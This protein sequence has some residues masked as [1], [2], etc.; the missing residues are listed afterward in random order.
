MGIKERKLREFENR[1][2]LILEAAK[3]LFSRNGFSNVTL[4]K[5][6]NEIEFSK[7]TIY[8]HFESKEE[9]YALILL[10]HLNILL[11]FLKQAVKT[12]KTTWEK[13]KS[14]LNA[15]LKFYRE[16]QEHFKLLFFIEMVS[17][18]YRIPK[19]LLKEIQM[20][21]IACLIE[22]QKV[23]KMGINSK[24]INNDYP[25]KQVA[26]MLWG[27]INGLIHLVESHQIKRSDL[28]HLIRI[29]FEIV[30]KGL[31]NKKN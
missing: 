23:I 20:Q 8:S 9:I 21:K 3:N 11:N 24:E 26:L 31:K 6:A 4:E 27:M 15:Y 22:L 30:S 17:N 13:I 16:N 10:E 2:N 28:D 19:K 14:C 12:E 25:I 29:G 1:K 5:I 7:G 18:H